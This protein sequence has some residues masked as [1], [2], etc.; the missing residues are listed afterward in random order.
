MRN[1]A[2]GADQ[3]AEVVEE[4][5]ETV[6]VEKAEAEAPVVTKVTSEQASA[7]GA[8]ATEAKDAP[9]EA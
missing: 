4:G 8:E 3:E 2:E 7:A 6:V 5:P 9:A 1:D